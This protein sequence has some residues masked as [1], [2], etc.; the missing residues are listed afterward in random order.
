MVVTESVDHVW[1]RRV[2]Y[3]SRMAAVRV[4]I[5]AS[6][7][8]MCRNVDQPSGGELAAVDVSAVPEFVAETIR[9]ATSNGLSGVAEVDG[10]R[11]CLRFRYI[12]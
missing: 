5:R 6:S 7:S 1:R 4:A 3:A 9:L 10:W 12:R 8:S 2:R 11:S